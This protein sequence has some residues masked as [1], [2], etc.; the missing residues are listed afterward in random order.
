MNNKKDLE[1]GELRIIKSISPNSTK[2]TK[3]EYKI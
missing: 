1:F 2:S 3:Y